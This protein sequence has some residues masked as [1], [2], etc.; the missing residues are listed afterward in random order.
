[1]KPFH[2]LMYSAEKRKPDISQLT[3]AKKESSTLQHSPNM[4]K[5]KGEVKKLSVGIVFWR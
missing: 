5:E 3:L 2:T 1:M 4:P